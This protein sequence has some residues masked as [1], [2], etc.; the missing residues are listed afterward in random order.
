M[1][2]VPTANTVMA[3]IRM[4]LASQKVE[5]TLFF[6]NSS[7][8]DAAELV[9]LGDALV[10]WFEANVQPLQATDV[11]L[12]EVY[13]TDL[14]SESAL[15]HTRPVVPNTP[16]GVASPA[17]P[18]NVT[19]TVSFRSAGRGRF[20]RGRNYFVG[21]TEGQVVNNLVSLTVADDL[22]LAYNA[23]LTA[24]PAG[25]TWVVCSRFTSAGPRV[26]GFNSPVVAAIVVDNVIDSQRR[27]LPGRGT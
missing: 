7:S 16:G 18:N 11:L 17:L 26:A 27:R 12:R 1:P 15:T 8:V 13:L 25:W 5:N 21:L 19:L 9:A 24:L 10:A 22:A 20:S 4:V 14:T 3:E 2:F 23:L 6:Q